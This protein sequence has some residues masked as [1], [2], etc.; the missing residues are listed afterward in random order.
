MRALRNY[1]LSLLFLFIGSAVMTASVPSRSVEIRGVWMDRKSIPKTE[2]GIRELIRSYAKAGINIVYPEVIFN[3]YS[4]YPSSYLTQMDLWDGIDMLGILIDE[5]HKCGIEVHPW[6]WVFRVGN[7]NDMGGIL[8]RHPDWAAVNKEGKILSE[9]GGYWL[10]PSHPAVRRLL[11]R[12][13]TELAVKYPVDGIQLDYIRFEYQEPVPT[14]YCD[15]C[16]RKFMEEHGIDPMKI[17]DFTNQAVIWHMWRE[18]LVN[19]FVRDVSCELRK[20][21]QN[22]KV[23]AAVFPDAKGARLSVLQD[24]LHWAVNGWVDFL[25]PMSYTRGAVDFQRTVSK[26]VESVG[27]F[28]F[29]A[30]GIGLFFLDRN[31]EKMIEQISISRDSGVAGVSLFASAYLDEKHLKA[32]AVGPFRKKAGLPFRA[33]L[34]QVKRIMS[35]V[36]RKLKATASSDVLKEASH[37]LG[38]A[39]QITDNALFW[40]KAPEYVEPKPPD[41]FVPDFVIPIPSIEALRASEAPTIDG[42]LDDSVWRSAAKAK[43]EY[44]LLGKEATQPTIVMLTYDT[45]NLYVAFQCFEPKLNVVRTKAKERDGL[46]FQDDSVEIFIGLNSKDYFHFVVNAEGICYDAKGYDA[47]WNADWSAAAGRESNGWIVEVSVPFSS[48]GK[49]PV[50]GESWRANFCRNRVLVYSEVET[51]CWSPTYGSLHTPKRFGEIRFQQ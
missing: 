14:C 20:T 13:I 50:S 1:C 30:P 36:K 5:A 18:N 41:I 9:R 12:A 42:K 15:R 24:W 43:I 47:S 33:S 4:A 29:L 17:E 44:T 32:L 49:T 34:E 48:L 38:L 22:L 39:K 8:K 40:S 6:V 27:F 16:R 25:A 7:I 21:R 35:E 45:N 23:S 31:P 51:T 10:C 26:A 19:T 11:M 46:V 2:K 37:E 28:S 3:G